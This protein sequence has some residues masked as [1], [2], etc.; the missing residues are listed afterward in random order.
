MP[1]LRFVLTTFAPPRSASECPF[2]FQVG[3]FRL[4]LVFCASHVF[5]E[6][7]TLERLRFPQFR[8]APYF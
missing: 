5:G 4:V 7:P 6:D 2:Q 8:V 1:G 3:G